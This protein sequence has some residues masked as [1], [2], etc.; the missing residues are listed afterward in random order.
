MVQQNETDL[1]APSDKHLYQVHYQ[2]IHEHMNQFLVLCI[3]DTATFGYVHFS[4]SAYPNPD[5]CSVSRDEMRH[6]VDG[7]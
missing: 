1:E 5:V 3:R 2:T 7:G 6:E 4:T